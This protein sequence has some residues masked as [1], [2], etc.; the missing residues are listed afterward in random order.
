VGV[1]LR[2]NGSGEFRYATEVLRE[3]PRSGGLGITLRAL[4]PDSPDAAPF[5]DILERLCEAVGYEGIVQA[6]FYRRRG[7]GEL[8]VLDVNPRLWG[9][10]WF[11]ERL[12][13]RV[14]E[15]SLRAAL[16]LPPLPPP[17]YEAG[18]TFHTADAELSW[19][20]DAPDPGRTALAYLRSLRPSDHFEWF[21][22]TDPWPTLV[23]ATSVLRKRRSRSGS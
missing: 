7:D 6:E 20:L 9:S 3:H 4:A 15:R 19:I 5:L 10:T 22:G 23:F 17:T 14:I 8:V 2:R 13:V 16:G 11:A 18:R 12:G 1:L 21:D